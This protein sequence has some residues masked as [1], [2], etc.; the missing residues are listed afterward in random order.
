M[1]A[2]RVAMAVGGAAVAWWWYS[3]TREVARKQ[4]NVPSLKH[5]ALPARPSNTALLPGHAAEAAERFGAHGEKTWYGGPGLF[6]QGVSGSKRVPGQPATE[7]SA[8]G[9]SK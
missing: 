6:K 8:A 1:P 2:C 5:R 9:G 4:G 3:S 7:S